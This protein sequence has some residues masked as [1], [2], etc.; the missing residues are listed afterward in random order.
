MVR[1][2]Q[3]TVC[4]FRRSFEEATAQRK[5]D[6]KL[7]AEQAKDAEKAKAAIDNVLAKI[8]PAKVTMELIEGDARL[9]NVPVQVVGR[10]H[11][12]YS[13]DNCPN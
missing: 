10:E 4:R 6:E 9:R 3:T 2:V 1:Q 11:F 8:S 7:S 13:S 5:R 12:I